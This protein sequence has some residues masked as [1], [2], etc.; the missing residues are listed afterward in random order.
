[1]RAFGYEPR[2]EVNCADYESIVEAVK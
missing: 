2:E 1:M